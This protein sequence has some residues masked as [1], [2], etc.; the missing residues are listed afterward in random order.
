MGNVA[1]LNTN[2]LSRFGGL[3]EER[4]PGVTHKRTVP[5]LSERHAK[6]LSCH[7]QALNNGFIV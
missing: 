1:E 5:N 6:S 4:A 2:M 7:L 3:T